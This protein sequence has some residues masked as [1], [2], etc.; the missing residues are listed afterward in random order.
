V[1]H[2]RTYTPG[3]VSTYQELVNL[4]FTICAV[5]GLSANFLGEIS[6]FN[7]CALLCSRGST[8]VTVFLRASRSS[9]LAPVQRVLHAAARLVNDLKTSDHVTSTLVDLHWMP[10]KQRVDYKLC[11]HV[12]NVSIGHAHAYLSDMLT[13]CADVPSFS[14]QRT[15]SSG[16]YVIP[17]T[18]LKLGERAWNNLPRELKK[19]KCTCHGLAEIQSDILTRCSTNIDNAFMYNINSPISIRNC[20]ILHDSHHRKYSSFFSRI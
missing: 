2:K 7:S 15:S 20:S 17:R 4:A 11:C 10:I 16:D 14:R 9:T 6:R 5:S 1:F 3:K 12:D 13:A 8:I 19:T 18:R